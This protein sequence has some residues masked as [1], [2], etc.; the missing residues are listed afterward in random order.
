MG[1][2]RPGISLRLKPLR[3]AARWEGSCELSGQPFAIGWQ[4]KAAYEDED[5]QVRGVCAGAGWGACGLCVAHGPT[6][7]VLV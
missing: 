3:L 5:G 4:L 1:R 2:P 7:D 6:T